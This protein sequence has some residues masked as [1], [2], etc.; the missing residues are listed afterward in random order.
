MALP[1]FP[2]LPLHRSPQPWS[3]RWVLVTSFIL[4]IGAAVGLTGWFSLQYGR[5]AVNDLARQLRNDISDRVE[6]H[7]DNY[8][9][10][11]QEINQL[12][13]ASFDLRLLTPQDL[14]T[15][16]RYFARQMAIFPVSYVNFGDPQGNFVGVERLPNRDFNL[17][18]VSQRLPGGIRRSYNSLVDPQGRILQTDNEANESDHRD[19]AWYLEA[20]AAKKP[21]WSKIYQWEDKPDILSISS[22]YPLYDAKDQLVGVLGV[23]H[24]LSQISQ[25]LAKIRVSDAGKIFVLERN[26]LLV[27]SSTQEPPFTIK[28]GKASRLLAVESQEPLIQETTRFLEQ[29]FQALDRIQTGQQLEFFFQR[30]RHFLQ[31]TPWRDPQGI[32]WL[33]VVVVPE[34][35]FMAQINANIRTTLI[36]CSL[37]FGGAIV[38][39][40]FTSRWI[41]API[42]GLSQASQAMSRG[43]LKQKVESHGIRELELLGR[44]FNSMAIQL[45]T[46]F[47]ALAQSNAELEARV[48]ERTAEL[49]MAKE[50]ADSASQAKSD[51]LASMSHELRTPLNGILGY[52]Q[53]MERSSSLDENDRH[54][55]EVIE[56]CSQHLLTLINDVLD[57]AKIEARKMELAPSELNFD[58]FLRG[59]VE[60]CRIRSQQKG[61]G[62][63][64]EPDP[65]LPKGVYADE[66]RLRQVLI[67]LLSNGIKF[68]NH[69][70]VIFGV[71]VKGSPL[72]GMGAGQPPHQ[73]IRF[74]VQD[75]GIGIAPEYMDQI[76]LPFEQVSHRQ[77]RGEG[78]GLGLAISQQIVQMMGGTIEVGSVLGQ[79]SLFA[80]TLML[81]IVELVESHDGPA[82]RED[83]EGDRFPLPSVS[84]V[85]MKLPPLP[86]LQHLLDLTR[87]GLLR[88]VRSLATAIGHQDPDLQPFAVAVEALAK[89]FQV[90]KL[91]LWLEQCVENR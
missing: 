75:T 4:Q 50:R 41:A 54:G 53:I 8:L 2:F 36:L 83:R 67:N 10:T 79:G 32:D 29:Q 91:K 39:G 17:S 16:G 21:I 11:P 37:A 81:P 77:Y 38:L 89:Q 35:D 23:D 76:F 49:Q 63:V 7:L 57:I 48:L 22:S 90:K 28:N 69:G 43:E 26:G 40:W 78:T 70:R 85:P 19:E 9:A 61:I 80:F 55:L 51:F 31:V 18:L 87:Q 66:K 25:F 52:V 44:S 3:L 14:Q 6:Q 58:L 27:A 64:Y 13:L 68:T 47:E 65:D 60:M 46:T 20:I 1:F 73:A 86:T 30:E 24:V 5:S 15:M 12:N 71:T 84:A 33:I 82:V 42:L 45:H 34:A 56:Q 74:S 59:V 62:F 72:P 88:D